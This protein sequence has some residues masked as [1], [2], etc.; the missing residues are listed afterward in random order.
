MT[1]ELFLILLAVFATFT[2]LF[3]EAIKKGLDS[4][5]VAY[6]SNIVVLC[7]S[8]LVGGI[9]TAVFYVFN[10]IAW[11]TTNTICMFLMV[12]ANWLVAMLG[13]DKIVQAITQL[14]GGKTK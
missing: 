7:A 8:A 11:T 1:I 9:G 13:Y 6:A 2:S 12:C 10:D 3:T 5:K 4:L 14:K